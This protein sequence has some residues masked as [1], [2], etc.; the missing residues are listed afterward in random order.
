[1][2]MPNRR[3]SALSASISSGVVQ[4]PSALQ[5]RISAGR[6][7]FRRHEHVPASLAS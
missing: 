3:K 5:E 4:L 7:L 1:M 2:S 6:A